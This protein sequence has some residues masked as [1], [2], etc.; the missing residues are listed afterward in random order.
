MRAELAGYADQMAAAEAEAVRLQESFDF[1][2]DAAKGVLSTFTQDLRNGEL[3]LRSFGDAALS[4]FDKI[5]DKLND[6]VATAFANA[7]APRSSGGGGGLFGSII[8]GLFGGGGGGA[9][10]GGFNIGNFYANGG[11]FDQ[12]GPVT[13]FARGGVVDRATVFPFA[14]GIGLMGEAGPEAIMPLKRGPDGRLGVSAQAPAA[15]SNGSRGGKSVI[16]LRLAPGLKASILE[17]AAD[18]SVDIVE[19]YDKK[20]APGTAR[21]AVG[22]ANKTSSNRAFRGR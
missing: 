22:R 11:V 6:Q 9:A 8:G 21:N 18:Q 16:L 7:F 5:V 10:L 14:K 17:E 2:K 19:E 4:V 20:A 12:N 3:S 15:N 13:A 1:T